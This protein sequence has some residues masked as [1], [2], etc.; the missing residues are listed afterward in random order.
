MTLLEYD[1]DL[2]DQIMMIYNRI[3]I[4]Q[5]AEKSTHKNYMLIKQLRNEV[6]KDIDALNI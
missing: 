3:Y 2:Y 1:E 6:I 4:L 5:I